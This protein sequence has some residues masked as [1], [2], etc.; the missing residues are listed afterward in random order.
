[1]YVLIAFFTSQVARVPGCED[2]LVYSGLY[3]Q[4]LSVYVDALYNCGSCV[5]SPPEP[6][7]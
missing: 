2:V 4:V 7:V 1:M 6:E 3:A 5:W